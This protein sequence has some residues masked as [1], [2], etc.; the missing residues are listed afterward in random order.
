MDLKQARQQLN[1]MNYHL[2]AAINIWYGL[3]ETFL[4]AFCTTRGRK[5]G[6]KYYLLTDQLRNAEKMIR[7]A[8]DYLEWCEKEAKEMED[9]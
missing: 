1:L 3:S 6:L 8:P 7:K 2:K 9:A 5:N 4:E